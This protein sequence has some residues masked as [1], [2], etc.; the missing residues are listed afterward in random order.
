MYVFYVIILKKA[1]QEDI[2]LGFLLTLSDESNHSKIEYIYNKYHDYM[3]KYA[4]SKFQTAGRN[5]FLFDAEDAVQNTFVKIIKYIN[6][7]DFSRS[8]KDIKNYCLTVLNN[9]ICHVLCDNEENLE[10]FEEFCSKKEY[11]FIEELEIHERYN[12]VVRAIDLLDEKYS[13]TLYL[14]FCKDMTVNEIS[15]MMD[16][17][18]KT[19]YTR[20]ERGKKLLLDS[21]KGAKI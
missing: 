9:E 16:I 2:M 8:E 7:I 20:L 6:Q 18:A 14:I 10:F 12:E 3:M 13:T 19:V 11:N 17:S 15:E 1:H 4:I 21:L 5:N